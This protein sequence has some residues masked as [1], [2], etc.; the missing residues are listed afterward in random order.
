[1]ETIDTN[2]YAISMCVWGGQVKGRMLKNRMRCGTLYLSISRLPA[3][4]DSEEL[5]L[6]FWLLGRKWVLLKS[7]G[8]CPRFSRSAATKT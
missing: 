7:G 6:T 5:N 2:A 1:M 8:Y 4:V 3:L